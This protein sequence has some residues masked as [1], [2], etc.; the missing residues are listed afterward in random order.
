MAQSLRLVVP[1]T[2]S[3]ASDIEARPAAVDNLP[4][5]DPDLLRH[6]QPAPRR[7]LLDRVRSVG[8]YLNQEKGWIASS[9]AIG[10]AA[11]ALTASVLAT[12]APAAVVA[13]TGIAVASLLGTFTRHVKENADRDY[14]QRLQNLGKADDQPGFFRRAK[15]YSKVFLDHARQDKL[16]DHLKTKQFWSR[17][18]VGLGV[19]GLAYWA[20]DLLASKASALPAGADSHAATT[21]P[22]C[23]TSDQVACGQVAAAPAAEPVAAATYEPIDPIESAMGLLNSH[24]VTGKAV[25]A[26]ETAIHNT[27]PQN[28][29]DAALALLGQHDDVAVELYQKAAD[30]GNV[31]AKIDL[32]F[33]K[34][35]GLH[36]VAADPQA[37]LDTMKEIKSP[38]AR[39]FVAQWTGAHPS[40]V[41][42]VHVIEQAS[43]SAAPVAPV[44][45]A[46]SG[47]AV[48]AVNIAANIPADA[49]APQTTAIAGDTVTAN[50][51]AE[52]APRVAL[53]CELNV[54]DR[55]EPVNGELSVKPSCV[56]HFDEVRAGDSIRLGDTTFTKDSGSAAS[57]TWEWAQD[58]LAWIVGQ[59]VQGAMAPH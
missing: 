9:A 50:P 20:S 2:L 26:I 41:P 35:H 48:P 8:R 47:A 5:I 51:D 44:A 21:T 38:V 37:A 30:A 53:E 14:A 43:A 52:L 24:E 46:V 34:F 29:K 7:S 54:P 36:G 28:V 57:K 25:H 56:Q 17:F 11:K 31:Q 6:P 10:I 59:K 45:P 16:E 32:A 27:T 13:G 42:P 22:A 49:Q 58:K 4:N 19:S 40:A 1:P 23:G 33:L 12:T 15:I 39:E 18:S 55:I 3:D